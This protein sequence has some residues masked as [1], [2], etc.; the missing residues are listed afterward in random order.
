M[1]L[2]L[3]VLFEMVEEDWDDGLIFDEEWDLK[4]G[5]EFYQDGVE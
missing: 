5:E 2:V 3:L 1:G 4:V